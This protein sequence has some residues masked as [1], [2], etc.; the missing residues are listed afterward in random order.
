M[1]IE[2]AVNTEVF[3]LFV[4]HFL[5]P[6]LIAGDIVL[7]DNVKL[8]YSQ[9][10]LDLIKASG[11]KVIHNAS[12]LTRKFNIAHYLPVSRRL[13]LEIGHP[14]TADNHGLRV[15]QINVRKFDG[16]RLLNL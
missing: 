5:V 9:R 2:G 13:Q 6:E 4:E 14:V 1:T 7:L 11:A 16:E 3:N 10:A 8:H 12:L 15:P